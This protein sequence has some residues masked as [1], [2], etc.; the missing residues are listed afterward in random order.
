VGLTLT[1][2]AY[3]LV[4]GLVID[5]E[6]NLPR[7]MAWAVTSTLPWLC[8]WEGLKRLG[9]WPAQSLQLLLSAGVLIAALVVCIALEYALGAIYSTDTD[10]LAQ[11]VY[12]LLP[13][14]VGIAVVRR[15]LQPSKPARTSQADPVL[16]VPT[17]QGTLAVRAC[18]IEYIKAA[19][20][21]VELVTGD[22][23]LLMRATL[24]DLSDQLAPI[25][26]LRVHRSLLVNPLHVVATRRGPR[27]R[28]IVEVRSGAELP[29]GRQFGDNAAAF[30]TIA[31]RSSQPD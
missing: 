6:M 27:G 30:V 28:R 1:A 23:T 4:H 16:N 3:C 14:P 29:V 18:D 8:A 7:T 12:R 17:R 25:G 10:S 19:G 15:L 31:Q 2:A 26:F 20:N 11:I 9:K 21:Y 22:R 13:I 5:V 24:Q